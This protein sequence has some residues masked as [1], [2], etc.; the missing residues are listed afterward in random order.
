MV[1]TG[2]SEQPLITP[3]LPSAHEQA[4]IHAAIVGQTA[5]GLANALGQMGLNT[6]EEDE[7]S[8][9]DGEE[10]SEDGEGVDVDGAESAGAATQNGG[11][12][13]PFA[14]GAAGQRCA[15]TS[16]VPN[17][18]NDEDDGGVEIVVSGGGNGGGCG[19]RP[20]SR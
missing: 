17:N 14:I 19:R 16:G 18:H 1:C 6:E 4:L 2:Y 13:Q 7:D 3:S 8:E 11:G 20:F 9:D 5:N 10:D 15:S 12:L